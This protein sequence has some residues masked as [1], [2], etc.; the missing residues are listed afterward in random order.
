MSQIFL[1]AFVASLAYCAAPG[2]INAEVIRRAIAQGFRVA[3]LFQV[4]ALVGDA[5]W[6]TVALSGLMVIRPYAGLHL[7]LGVCGALLLLGM[8]SGA[9]RDSL[10]G[11][12]P[13]ALRPRRQTDLLL[14]A[15]LSLANPFAIA[16][17]LS[18][19]SGLLPASTLTKELPAVATAVGAFILAT[20]IWSILLAAVA[21]YGRALATAA[22]LRC[23]NAGAGVCMALFGFGPFWQTLA[24]Y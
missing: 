17:W 11:Q 2:A 22:A 6:A 20:L 7:V 5:L 8:A 18:I 16:F 12:A 9:L 21:S 15:L 13:I 23:L 24:A 19:G 1:S 14:G 3:L 10:C 4:G